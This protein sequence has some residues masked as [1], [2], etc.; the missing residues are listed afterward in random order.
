MSQKLSPE[1]LPLSLRVDLFTALPI[2]APTYKLRR[3][4]RPAVPGM[5]ALNQRPD[6]YRIDNSG[7]K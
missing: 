3:V 7:N 2:A 5:S 6:R 1:G 4:W